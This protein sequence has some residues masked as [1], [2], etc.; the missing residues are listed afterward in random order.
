MNFLLAIYDL[1][2]FIL[3]NNV[4]RQKKI[5]VIHCHLFRSLIFG[6]MIKLIIPKV[7]FV[8]QEHGG[9]IMQDHVF[10]RNFQ[11]LFL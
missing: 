9:I 5:N 6:T 7:K 3:V 10:R 1:R 4:V 2:S 11:I 8:Y